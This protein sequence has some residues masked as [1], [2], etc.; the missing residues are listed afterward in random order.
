MSQL[1][2]IVRRVL[3]E[4]EEQDPS[5]LDAV[6]KGEARYGRGFGDVGKYASDFAAAAADKVA[7]W[8]RDGGAWSN[9]A[10]TAGTVL[11]AVGRA[12]ITPFVGQ[13]MAPRD[14]E[15]VRQAQATEYDPILRLLPMIGDVLAYIALTKFRISAK[16]TDAVGLPTEEVLAGRY[17]EDPAKDILAG[18]VLHDVL[19]GATFVPG[20]AVAAMLLDSVVYAAEGEE[21]AAILALAMAGVFHAGGKVAA[22]RADDAARGVV[23]RK[24]GVEI[25]APKKYTDLNAA[26]KRGGFTHVVPPEDRATAIVKFVNDAGARMEAAGVKGGS[27]I[28]ASASRAVRSG[29]ISIAPALEGARVAEAQKCASELMTPGP[30]GETPLAAASRKSHRTTTNRKG[31]TVYTGIAYPFKETALEATAPNAA[32]TLARATVKRLVSSGESQVLSAP[33][34]VT[35][36]TTSETLDISQIDPLAERE[37]RQSKRRTAPKVGFYAYG[38][39]VT[40]AEVSR[41]GARKIDVQLPAGTKV[42]DVT[43]L[44]RGTSARITKAEAEALLAQGVQVIRGRDLIGPPEYV[45]LDRSLLKLPSATTAAFAATAGGARS[46]KESALRAWVRG[47]I[48]EDRHWL[49]RSELNRRPLPY[50][51]SALT[52]ELLD[53]E[54]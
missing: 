3:L 9:A 36:R 33:L 18:S 50:Q 42:L 11:S 20:A 30:S 51:G 8:A 49:S 31:R 43:S 47:I 7:H 39:E 1:N 54:W 17:G 48:L 23:A 15:D 37:S 12:A 14:E 2:S 45:I 16:V 29:E 10:E 19:L 46:V 41:Y 21:E 44:D 25:L 35:H 38:P 40:D 24:G 53:T 26:A 13:A 6:G 52:P 32:A 27:Q 34:T 5:Y 28:A 4:A 22:G